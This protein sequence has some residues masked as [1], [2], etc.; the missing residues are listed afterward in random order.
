[1]TER[2]RNWQLAVARSAA[3]P[4][5][6]D[7][8]MERHGITPRRAIRAVFCLGLVCVIGMDIEILLE[9]SA[10]VRLWIVVKAGLTCSGALLVPVAFFLLLRMR[11]SRWTW[12]ATGVVAL[13]AVPWFQLDGVSVYGQAG[14]WEVIVRVGMDLCVY[15]SLMG[16]GAMLYLFLF[17]FC[18]R[19]ALLIEQERA[20]QRARGEL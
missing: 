5:W 8:W 12:F 2:F 6:P 11:A 16:V 19:I 18:D 1:M 14:I 9:S 3:E 20:A 4:S 17:G 7:L 13:F 10:G 15:G